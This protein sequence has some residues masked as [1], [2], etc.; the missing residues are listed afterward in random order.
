MANHIDLYLILCVILYNSLKVIRSLVI[1]ILVIEIR[2]LGSRISKLLYLDIS[3]VIRK[4]VFGLPS[5]LNDNGYKLIEIWFTR[6]KE[7]FCIN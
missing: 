1:K 4:F 7:R 6:F 5:S 2:E 3:L